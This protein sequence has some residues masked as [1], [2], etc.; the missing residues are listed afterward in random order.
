M[1]TYCI[2]ITGGIGSGKST[3]AKNFQSFGITILSADLIAKNLTNKTTIKNKIKS[4]FG[5]D[6]F[7][8]EYNLNRSKLRELIFNDITLKQKLES[9]LHPLIKKQL[10]LDIKKVKS[11]YCLIEIPLLNRRQDFPYIDRVL[12]IVINEDKQLN[13][14]TN[15]DQVSK[16][17]AKKIVSQQINNKKRLTLADDVI[18]N[19]SDL[20]E[21]KHKCFNL[22]QSYL[23]LLK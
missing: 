1:K 10:L 19:N 16:H 17:S 18:E 9:I 4:I 15:R 6:I 2:A 22:H 7:D 14:V 21:L 13:H 12:C 3:V 5:P 8:N 23:K 11:P 20:L